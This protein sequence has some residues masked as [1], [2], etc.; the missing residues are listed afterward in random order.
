MQTRDVK[1]DYDIFEA[2]EYMCSPNLIKDWSIP[3][4]LGLARS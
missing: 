4:A 2:S 1:H 3:A